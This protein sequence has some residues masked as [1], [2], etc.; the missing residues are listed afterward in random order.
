M[1]AVQRESPP[2]GKA[3]RG[4][5][6]WRSMT[7]ARR[8]RSKRT[9]FRRCFHQTSFRRELRSKVRAIPRGCPAS[10]SDD[11]VDSDPP[12]A[13]RH[14]PPEPGGTVHCSNRLLIRSPAGVER[15]AITSWQQGD[16]LIAGFVG[17][18]YMVDEA[19]IVGIG[20][21]T[22][23]RGIG[24]GEFL[25][26]S[27]IEQAMEMKSQGRHAG[28]ARLEPRCPETSTRSTDSPSAARARG[29]TRTT[30]RTR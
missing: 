22:E 24:L 6:R 20:V 17:M 7:W 14:D 8:P 2:Q 18:W 10:M 13:A 25:L 29:T 3:V 23:Y 27:A 26:I 30:A 5:S 4:P 28:S 19:H 16:E 21:R 15:T 1:S 11:P 12:A 9:P